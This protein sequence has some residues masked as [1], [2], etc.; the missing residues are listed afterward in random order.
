MLGVSEIGVLD[1]GGLNEDDRLLV[2]LGTRFHTSDKVDAFHG[3]LL[4]KNICDLVPRGFWPGTP[5]MR[6]Y[7]SNRM[8]HGFHKGAVRT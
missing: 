7:T 5:K 4:W 2:V 6:N 3:Q 1:S 8:N